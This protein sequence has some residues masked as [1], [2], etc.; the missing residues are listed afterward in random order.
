MSTVTS[1]GP[2]GRVRGVKPAIGVMTCASCASCAARIE[3]VLDAS[4]TG[5]AG[6]INRLGAR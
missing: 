3:L 5:L 2:A 1:G 6:T 4:G